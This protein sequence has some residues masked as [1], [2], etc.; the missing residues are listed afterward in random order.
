MESMKK[1]SIK[2]MIRR[3]EKHLADVAKIRD[4]IDSSISEMSDLRDDC[5][6][7]WDSLQRARDALSELV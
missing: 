6:N 3:V 5:E 2:S 1:M 4:T 7:A